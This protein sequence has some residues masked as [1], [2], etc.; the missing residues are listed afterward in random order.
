MVFVSNMSGLKVGFIGG[1]MMAEAMLS[2]LLKAGTTKKE[3]VIVSEPF[4]ERRKYMADTYGVAVTDVNS[5]VVESSNDGVVV[6]SV[7]PQVIDKVLQGL[8]PTTEKGPLFVS[9]IAGMP[10]EKLTKWSPEGRFC[11]TMPN[12]PALVGMGATAYVLSKNCQSTDAGLVEKLMGSIGIVE[13]VDKEE[14]LDAVTGMSGG[15]PAYVYMMIEA[16]SDGGV[17]MGLP[18]K[19]ATRLAAQTVMGAGK[20][21]VDGTKHPGELKDAVTS[22]GGTTIAG[23]QALEQGCFRGTIIN[24]VEA[25]TKRSQELGE[26]LEKRSRLA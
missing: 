2:G 5:L 24:A 6:L 11:R 8:S 14:L 12:T 17:R 7:K 10:I 16:M 21:V 15:G 13:K 19:L 3:D 1:G 20:M 18:R 26:P 25:A 9:I 22:P 4:E 23:V